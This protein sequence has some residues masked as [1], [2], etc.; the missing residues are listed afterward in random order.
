MHCLTQ[1]TWLRH[2]RINP[3]TFLRANFSSGDINKSSLSHRQF[4]DVESKGHRRIIKR[5]STWHQKIVKGST[6]AHRG[7]F[8]NCILQHPGTSRIQSNCITCD[9]KLHDSE[10]NAW[11]RDHPGHAETYEREPIDAACR[12]A[13]EKNNK[14]PR[15]SRGRDSAVE[16]AP[17]LAL[18]GR[19]RAQSTVKA[20]NLLP[21]MQRWRRIN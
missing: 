3:K 4:I 14:Q 10:K 18:A 16:A 11:I 12:S 13:P 1:G 20:E 17:A 21:L 7:T 9:P 6:Q 8:S 2:P 5:S 19:C 15:S